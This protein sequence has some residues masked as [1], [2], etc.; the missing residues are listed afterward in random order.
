MEKVCG[1][2]PLL[3]F[4]KGRCSPGGFEVFKGIVEQAFEEL[5]DRADELLTM[6]RTLSH[7]VEQSQAYTHPDVIEAAKILEMEMDGNPFVGAALGWL[8]EHMDRDAAYRIGE[9][10]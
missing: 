5:D 7:H 8:V 6:A 3:E 2:A 9:E 10:E 1:I 4:A